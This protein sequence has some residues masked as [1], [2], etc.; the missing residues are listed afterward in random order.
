MSDIAN[1][2]K[3]RLGDKAKKVPTPQTARL[4]RLDHRAL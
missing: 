2:L 1:V 3:E 4:A